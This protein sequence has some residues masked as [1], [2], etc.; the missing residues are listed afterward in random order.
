V[1]AFAV[2]A[3]NSG[4]AAAMVAAQWIKTAAPFIGLA[5]AVGVFA[6]AIEDIYQTMT[7][8]KGQIGLWLDEWKGAGT[9]D[10]YVRNLAAGVE[11]LKDAV[12]GLLDLDF[13]KVGNMFVGMGDP[14]KEDRY[15]FL[16][17]RVSNLKKWGRPQKEIDA[18]QAELDTFKRQ[19]ETLADQ[20]AIARALGQGMNAGVLKQEMGRASIGSA[21]ANPNATVN[22]V[23]VVVNAQ[24]NADPKEIGRHVTKVVGEKLAQ[25]NRNL[26]AAHARQ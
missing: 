25:Q 3:T 10:N 12:K 21:S 9:V 7:G 22:N 2:I 11:T 15:G 4:R 13:S 6:L 5:V 20:P 16:S 23:N 26:K 19:N 18:A 17:E 24:T 8:G 14:S 1:S